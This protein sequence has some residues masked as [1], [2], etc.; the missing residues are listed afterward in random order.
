LF[1]VPL[2]R[3]PHI[4]AGRIGG[5]GVGWEASCAHSAQG[6]LWGRP[7][8]GVG[9]LERVRRDLTGVAGST[10][11]R[12]DPGARLGQARWSMTQSHSSPRSA[13]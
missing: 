1:F 12:E 9:A 2:L 8:N 3:E 11:R 10:D 4:G 7:T 13:S 6:G 5:W